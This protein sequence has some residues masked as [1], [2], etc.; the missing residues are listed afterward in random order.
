MSAS[1]V[2]CFKLI[3]KNSVQYAN[4][5]SPKSRFIIS[6]L[7]PKTSSSPDLP[8]IASVG[9]S[10]SSL[11]SPEIA[12]R[13]PRIIVIRP[14]PPESTTPAFLST[15]SSSG[16]FAS[17]SSPTS[18]N[19]VRKATK[20]LCLPASFIADSAI[21]LTT[22]KIVPSLGMETALYA[23]F[24]PDSIAFAKVLVSNASLVFFKTEQMPL[25]ICEDITPELPLAPLSAPFETESQIS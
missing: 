1:V 10:P 13:N 23:T 25:K 19:A 9:I 7:S 8:S 15:G 3:T 17:A 4:S 11:S 24:E 21:S 5:I 18:I 12:A 20:S 2:I 16:V 6:E 22:V 14:T